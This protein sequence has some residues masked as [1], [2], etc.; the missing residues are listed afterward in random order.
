MVAGLL[1]STLLS[2]PHDTPRST[3]LG[4]GP[5]I[6]P[7][8]TN[9]Q[10]V[11]EV[12]ALIVR[13]QLSDIQSP[14]QT[15][16]VTVTGNPALPNQPLRTAAWRDNKAPTGR[17]KA[18]D[19]TPD[20]TGLLLRAIN[21]FECR[22]FTKNAFP[23]AEQQVQWAHEA[24]HAVNQAR[25]EAGGYELTDR[26][27]GIVRG[28]SFARCFTDRF[29]QIKT[30]KSNARND[31]IT[32]VRGGVKNTY[33]FQ[34]TQDR[35]SLQARENVKLYLRLMDDSSFLYKVSFL[36]ISHNRSRGVV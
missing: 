15:G 21:E 6:K 33:G 5:A 35:K 9:P 31:V 26:M 12:C 20:V 23:D 7:G 2:P 34:D 14:Q 22:V 3:S 30:R 13:S 10:N 36:S 28:Q 4:P 8:Q 29:P 24:W 25:R 19:Y 11:A 1:H 32:V 17:A 16:E 18:A 27:I